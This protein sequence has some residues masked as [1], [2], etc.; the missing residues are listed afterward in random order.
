MA[1]LEA[2]GPSIPSAE[3]SLCG[4]DPQALPYVYIHDGIRQ[5]RVC[6][7]MSQSSSTGKLPPHNYRTALWSEPCVM[8]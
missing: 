6:I 7:W 4:A 8:G 3:R 2:E 1:K 5:V